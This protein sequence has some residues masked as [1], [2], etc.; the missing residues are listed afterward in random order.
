[1]FNTLLII[2]KSPNAQFLSCNGIIKPL[3]EDTSSQV[4]PDHFS[5]QSQA[6]STQLTVLTWWLLKVVTSLDSVNCFSLGEDGAEAVEV[7]CNRGDR[8]NVLE[9]DAGGSLITH[10]SQAGLS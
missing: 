2:I 6:P 5:L 10:L 7:L 1:L 8:A 3:C 9:V 4:F